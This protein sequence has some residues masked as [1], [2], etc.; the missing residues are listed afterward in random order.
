AALA[1]W[2]ANGCP[3]NPEAWLLTAARRKQIDAARR[4]RSG[5]AAAA[6]LEIL[7]DELDM[8][9]HGV[10]PDRRLALMFACAHPALDA[11]IRAPLMLQTVM[12]LDAKRIASAFLVSPEA[13]GKRLGRAKEKIRDAGIRLEVPERDDLEG[14]LEAVL[15]AIYAAYAEGWSDPA[16]TH[17][18]RRDPTPEGGSPPRR[19]GALPPR[20]G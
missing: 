19:P 5:E 16:G 14:R 13:M 18:A 10:I 6:E 4:R 20:G 9:E 1:D 17:A 7:A 15:E 3:R 8:A 2:P 11:G 12:G